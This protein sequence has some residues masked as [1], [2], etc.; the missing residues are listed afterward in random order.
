MQIH[1]NG[2]DADIAFGY[3]KSD[4]FTESMRIKG[5]GN[6][7][8]GIST[9]GFPLSFPDTLG[10][11][12]SLSGQSGAHYGIGI[13][14]NLLQ[15]HTKAADGD[16]A[17][18]YGKSDSFTEKMRIKGNG[19]VGI[20]I[21]TPGFPLSF[22]DTLG[23]KISLYGQSGAHYGIG[24]QGS[25]LQIHTNGADADIAFGYGKSDSFTEKMRIKGNGNV[26]IGEMATFDAAN[27]RID[28]PSGAPTILAVDLS[29]KGKL[30]YYWAATDST[31]GW[32]H[33]Q[34]AGNNFAASYPGPNPPSDVRLKTELHLIPSALEKVSQL[35]GVTFHWNE[36]GLQYLTRD[37]ATTL[38]AGP[39]ATD[40]N[41][42][43]LWQAERDKRNKSFKDQVRESLP[44]MWRRCCPKLLPSMKPDI[45]R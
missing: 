38:S 8:I 5:N 30:M 1:T 39:G 7:G 42:R 34:N 16:I 36:Q 6:V 45:S 23:D 4:S 40:E 43:K 25:L 12:I 27:K 15:I 44:R 24:I 21:N 41:N 33:I 14:G 19:N 29:V 13:Q 11:K 3:G 35:R 37:I 20:G 2:A 28:F 32:K 18:G 31:A 10:D 9:P 17:F 22:P 26:S